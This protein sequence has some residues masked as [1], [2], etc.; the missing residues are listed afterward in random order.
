MGNVGSSLAER[1]V[2]PDNNVHIIPDR[3]RSLHYRP[4][5][6]RARTE[7]VRAYP[8]STQSSGYIPS[9]SVH[10]IPDDEYFPQSALRSTVSRD[11][12]SD[13]DM[14]LSTRQRRRGSFVDLTNEATSP[15]TLNRRRTQPRSLKRAAED[16]IAESSGPAKRTRPASVI[17]ELDL[18]NE[19][20]S[21]E[22]ELL[23]HQQ[24]A[25]VA[26]QQASEA[27]G[28]PQKIGKRQCIICMENYTNMT[29]THCGHVYCHECLTQALKAGERAGERKTG[30]C[31]VCRKSVK[32][33]KDGKPGQ[34]ISINFMKKS[35]FEGK[36]RQGR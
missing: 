30:T 6:P 21:A 10:S 24:A 31:P 5:T 27:S 16:A 18:T 1:H 7:S 29:A 36:G 3:P 22:D 17:E 20:P 4:S 25:T 33:P 15:P 8:D 12:I 28:G 14:P 9:E 32:R 2:S 11:Q 26:A 23:A 35:A 19:N 34:M 13:D